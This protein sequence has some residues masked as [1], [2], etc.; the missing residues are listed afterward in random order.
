MK[1]FFILL[2]RAISQSHF[3]LLLVGWLILGCAASWGWAAIYNNMIWRWMSFNGL[4][5]H[6]LFHMLISWLVPGLL[7]LAMGVV[8]ARGNQ[9]RFLVVSA[10]SPL[11]PILFWLGAFVIG[12]SMGNCI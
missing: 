7:S 9:R 11:V 1:K 10:L 3:G 2:D 4:G 12:C 5:Y 6:P 8:I